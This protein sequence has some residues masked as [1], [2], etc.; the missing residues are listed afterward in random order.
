MLL[1]TDSVGVVLEGYSLAAGHRACKPVAVLP[2]EGVA[3][4][5]VVAEGIACG[6]VGDRLS[7]GMTVKVR[8]KSIDKARGRIGLT[9][10]NK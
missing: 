1:C 4:S 5:V 10:K 3:L 8:V 9:M 2:C 7:V 6:V